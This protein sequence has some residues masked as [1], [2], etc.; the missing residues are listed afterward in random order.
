MEKLF[1]KMTR[2]WH[3]HV[4]NEGIGHRD[5]FHLYKLYYH[6]MAR[7]SRWQNW[8]DFPDF[9]QK[10]NLA[11]HAICLLGDFILIRF[12]KETIYRKCQILFPWENRK[13]IIKLSAAEIFTQQPMCKPVQCYACPQTWTSR[14]YHQLIA[15]CVANSVV[16]PDKTCLIWVYAACPGLFVYIV[17]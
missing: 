2:L 9:P 6:A 7:Y 3:L 13:K 8:W 1:S 16:Y 12:D 4:N 14:F 5:S 11:L 17:P 10:E 15:G